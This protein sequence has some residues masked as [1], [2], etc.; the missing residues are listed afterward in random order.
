MAN[1][2]DKR[3]ASDIRALKINGTGSANQKTFW[4]NL[5]DRT[6]NDIVPVNRK[7]N[8]VLVA[9]N[10]WLTYYNVR[11]K[12]IEIFSGD[13]VKVVVEPTSHVAT[14]RVAA[15]DRRSRRCLFPGEVKVR[16]NQTG[17]EDIFKVKFFC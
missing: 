13:V 4:L 17:P 12:P 16:N 15:V 6:F 7:R 2:L 14:E 3:A 5:A 10:D 9:I 1:A 11:T 8:S